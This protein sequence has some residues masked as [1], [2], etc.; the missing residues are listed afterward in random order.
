MVITLQHKNEYTYIYDSRIRRIHPGLQTFINAIIITHERTNERSKADTAR[1]QLPR[2]THS[3]SR[4]PVF[5][6]SEHRNSLQLAISRNICQ[7]QNHNLYT[8]CVD[9]TKFFDTMKFDNLFL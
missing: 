3:S 5:L 6:L 8:N 9:L 1:F 7:E 4:I 2:Y